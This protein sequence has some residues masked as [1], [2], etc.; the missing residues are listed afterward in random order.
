MNRPD[1][2]P[3]EIPETDRERR[4]RTLA[5]MWER[6]IGPLDQTP[7]VKKA[8]FE[9]ADETGGLKDTEG[10]SL[11]DSLGKDAFDSN[12]FDGAFDGIKL[13]DSLKMP[14]F[15]MPS[16]GWLRSDTD[17]ASGSGSS[18]SSGESWWSRHSPSSPQSGGSSFGGGG[19]WNLGIPG[20][21]GSWTKFVLLALIIVGGVIAWRFWKAKDARRKDS[22]GLGG[23]AG[24]PVDPWRITTREEVVKAFEYLSILICGPIARSWTHT[25]IADALAELATTHADTA[26]MLA[27]LYELAR[28]TPVDEPLTTTELAE[29]R[30]LVC[31]LAGLENG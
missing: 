6:N 13:G 9:F 30:R 1:P 12:S 23:L 26:M 17:I 18:P 22:F 19:S 8:I 24:W 15:D 27:R 7:S 11:W 3:F 5:G 4:Q 28:Y 16:F 29:A 25:T 31:R 2:S 10:K 20:F 21:S 14:S